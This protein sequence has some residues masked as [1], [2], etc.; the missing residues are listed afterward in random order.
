MN[1]APQVLPPASAHATGLPMLT[2]LSLN[3]TV[4][5]GV[6]PDPCVGVTVAVNVTGKP[7]SAGLS[8]E[9][10]PV[11]VL[12]RSPG[13]AT[14]FVS[15]SPK[16]AVVLETVAWLLYCATGGELT[17]TSNTTRMGLPTG[18]VGVTSTSTGGGGGLA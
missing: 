17:V 3:C 5:S 9:T 15:T 1:C 11:V 18:S 14:V 10:S 16:L 7:W 13:V 4:P 12:N 2:A 8:D 6:R